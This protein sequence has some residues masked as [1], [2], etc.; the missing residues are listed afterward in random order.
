[1]RQ[2]AIRWERIALRW[3]ELAERRQAHYLD[4]YKSGR[5]RHYYTEEEFRAELRDTIALVQRWSAI[6]PTREERDEAAGVVR[7]AAA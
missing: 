1:M 7:Q 4:L 3:R 2:A 6:A 5:W